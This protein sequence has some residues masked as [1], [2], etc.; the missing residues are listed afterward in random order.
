MIEIL[1]EERHNR[2]NSDFSQNI[3]EFKERNLALEN[4]LKTKNKEIENLRYKLQNKHGN[5]DHILIETVKEDQENEIKLLKLHIEELK[6]ENTFIES[7]YSTLVSHSKNGSNPEI[8]LQSAKENLH[9]IQR[10]YNKTYKELKRNLDEQIA[11]NKKL[12]QR[13]SSNKAEELETKLKEMEIKYREQVQYNKDLQSQMSYMYERDAKTK[14]KS[15]VNE[16][17]S[18]MKYNQL[19]ISEL[20]DKI[21]LTTYKYDELK[22]QITTIN[23]TPKKSLRKESKKKK[24]LS[25]DQKRRSSNNTPS[26]RKTPK[27][28]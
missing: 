23:D 5:S 26:S 12:N 10:E 25:S 1:K 21:R 18:Q 27:I 22:E 17:E 19:K 14:V 11:E 4:E 7:Q 8:I 28:M 2:D 9:S 13:L 15:D 20:E 6:E 16:F 24:H 3:K